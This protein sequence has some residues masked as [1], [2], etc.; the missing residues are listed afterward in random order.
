MLDSAFCWFKQNYREPEVKVFGACHIWSLQSALHNFLISLP[1]FSLSHHRIHWLWLFAVNL[2]LPAAFIHHSS[3]SEPNADV[4]SWN[5]LNTRAQWCFSYIICLFIVYSV[6]S[7]IRLFIILSFLKHGCQ[8]ISCESY[9]LTLSCS[10]PYWDFLFVIFGLFVSFSSSFCRCFSRSA[11]RPRLSPG[12]P[13]V[14]RQQG[15]RLPDVA[16]AQCRRSLTRGGLL[17]GKV[18]TLC[19]F[20]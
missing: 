2:L 10:V 19:H 11:R 1:T 6:L 13:G 9:L 16:A 20:K 15:L 18:R 8:H 7:S 4:K 3:L 17:C 14:W 12:C 5:R